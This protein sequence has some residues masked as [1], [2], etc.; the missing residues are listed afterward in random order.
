LVDKEDDFLAFG[1]TI[2][3]FVPKACFSHRVADGTSSIWLL[4]IQRDAELLEQGKTLEQTLR[5][6]LAIAVA[7]RTSIER[8][9]TERERR[10]GLRRLRDYVGG[11]DS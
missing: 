5:D 9:N 6:P 2:F 8:L 7:V 10:D 4:G 3:T 11:H 1:G